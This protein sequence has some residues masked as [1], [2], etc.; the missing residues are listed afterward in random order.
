[1]L[2]PLY[3]VYSIRYFYASR[4]AQYQKNCQ[5]L[6]KAGSQIFQILKVDISCNCKQAATSAQKILSISWDQAGFII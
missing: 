2:I 6:D 4:P 5:A 1:M 3:T